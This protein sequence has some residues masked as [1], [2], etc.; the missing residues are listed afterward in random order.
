MEKLDGIN[1]GFSLALTPDKPHSL[2]QGAA[3]SRQ[4]PHPNVVSLKRAIPVRLR[5]HH[6]LLHSLLCRGGSRSLAFSGSA[7]P[8]LLSRFSG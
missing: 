1:P 8:F 6:P 4:T 7:S 2:R 5:S 3:N